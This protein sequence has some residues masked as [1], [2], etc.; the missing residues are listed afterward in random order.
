M[1]EVYAESNNQLLIS[2]EQKIKVGRTDSN[3]LCI[4]H[5]SVSRSHAEI[6]PLGS[7]WFIKD[8]KST[9]ATFLNG[10]PLKPEIYYLLRDND[11]ISFGSFVSSLSAPFQNSSTKSLIIFQDNTYEGSFIINSSALFSYGGHQST[12]SPYTKDIQELCFIIKEDRSL[13][14]LSPKSS[15]Q[16]ILLNGQ[17]IKMITE[18]SD[19]DEILF[20]THRIIISIPPASSRNN[21]K[22]VRDDDTVVLPDYLVSRMGEDNWN[23]PLEI[24]RKNTQNKLSHIPPQETEKPIRAQMPSELGMSRFTRPSVESIQFQEIEQEKKYAL[25]G[26]ITLVILIGMLSIIF[27]VYF[28]VIF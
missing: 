26:V 5:E 2:S 21:S 25:M 7:D 27:N 14:F 6:V 4:P 22:T 9:N 24:K 19:R 8:L 1:I 10:T 15:P 16:P 13:L 17:E 20:G 11:K 23:D 18:L 12:I 28:R 3:T